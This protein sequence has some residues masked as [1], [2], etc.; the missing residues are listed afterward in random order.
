MQQSNWRMLKQKTL[1]DSNLAHRD[2][3]TGEMGID[4]Q[5]EAMCEEEDIAISSSS[6]EEAQ[7]SNLKRYQRHLIRVTRRQII[8]NAFEKSKL[9]R[10]WSNKSW[11]KMI[12]M[13]DTDGEPIKVTGYKKNFMAERAVLERL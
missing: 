10:L 9:K 7:Q 4:Q 12:N 8:I 11:T 2:P 6:E 3:L 5:T 13:I 1:S